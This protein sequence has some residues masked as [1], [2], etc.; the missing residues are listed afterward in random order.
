M[1]EW[2][3][4]KKNDI[5]KPIRITPEADVTIHR[6]DEGDQGTFSILEGPRGFLCHTLELPN[7]GNKS[8]ISCIPTGLYDVVIRK[9]KKYGKVYHIQDVK[10]RT[11]ILIHSGNVAGDVAKGWHTHSAGCIL[12]GKYRGVLK[13]N[14]RSQRA[15]LCSKPTIREF[16]EL[17]GYKPFK[18]RIV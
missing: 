8:N 9:S 4:R 10:G 7:R 15:V 14:G 12:M 16:V 6:R 18:L 17:M 5:T 3:V 2:F 11:F 1:F 13:C